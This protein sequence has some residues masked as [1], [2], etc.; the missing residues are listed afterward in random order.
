MYKGGIF[1]SK[2]ET[3]KYISVYNYNENCVCINVAPNKS[4][5]LDPA[6]YGEPT[7]IPLSLEEIKFANNSQVFK[8]GILEFSSDIESDIFE[9]LRID[10]SKVLKLND[11]KEIL[12]H[13]TKEG[14]IK[15]LSIN[16]LSNFDRVRG[17]FQKL[18]FDGYKL[19]LDVADL[20]ERR[21]K[22]LFN[23]QIKSSIVIDDADVPHSHSD[24]KVN[25]LEKEIA[26]LKALL[27]AQ[28]SNNSKENIEQ[29]SELV[30]VEE[31]IETENE[32]DKTIS[33][34]RKAGRPP[35]ARV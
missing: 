4:I 29:K 33:Q 22:E 5:K 6:M 28:M 30:S 9:E 16:S 15:I 21:T 14:L 17:Q 23:N 13:P 7:V 27:L 12:L 10:A 18:K 2:L 34:T 8:T 31:K 26:E 25:E 11:I 35:K 1:I 24:K 32:K 20:I 3:V 19:T